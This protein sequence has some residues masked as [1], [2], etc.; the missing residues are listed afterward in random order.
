MAG[1]WPLRITL[2]PAGLARTRHRLLLLRGAAKREVLQRALAGED[3]REM[4]IR[5]VLG[6]P[7][8]PLRVH[9]CP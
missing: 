9:W 8:R 6:L 4:P 7:G 1:D 5:V 3:V 2:T